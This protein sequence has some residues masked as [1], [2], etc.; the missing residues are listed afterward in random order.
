MI[1]PA[2][3]LRAAPKLIIICLPLLLISS[4]QPLSPM[5]EK[6]VGSWSWR[7]IEG[8]GRIVFSVDRTVREGFPPDDK[9]GRRISDDEFEIFWSGTWR[10]EREV[11]ITEMDNRPFLK[12]MKHLDSS[13]AP[14][15][16][17]KIKRQ[18]IVKIDGNK[19]VFDDGSSLDRVKR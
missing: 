19:M 2:S 16:E 4:Q 13:H 11:L 8:F 17:C 18:K 9:D 7:Y 14:G 5:E 1:A 6:V 10:V 12:L 15:L 3:V